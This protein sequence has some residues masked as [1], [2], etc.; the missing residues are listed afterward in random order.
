MVAYPAAVTDE[1]LP[2]SDLFTKNNILYI[3]LPFCT[4]KCHYCSYVTKTVDSNSEEIDSY[5][6][7]L[8]KE[9]SLL[10]KKVKISSIYIGGGTPSMLNLLQL[11]KLYDIIDTYFD[12]SALEEYTLEGCPET[13]SS[14]KALHAKQRGITR[15]SIGVESFNDDILNHMNRRHTSS[16]S[17]YA[18]E[19]I[20]S[21]GLDL[22]ID[23]ITC[24][25]GYNQDKIDYDLKC[26]RNSNPTSVSTY[27]YTVKP[28][29]VDFKHHAPLL[30]RDEV[31]NQTRYWYTGLKNLG[32][33]QRNVDWFFVDSEKR[34]LHQE[35]KL[36]CSANHIVLGV[37]GYGIIGD[38]QYYNTKSVR[39]YKQLLEKNVLPVSTMQKLTPLELEKRK[40]MFGVR[41]YLDLSIEYPEKEKIDWLLDKQLLEKSKRGLILTDIGQLFVN[42]IQ[43]YLVRT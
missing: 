32:Y 17:L 9:A 33:F 39:E 14:E 31:L 34:F 6:S 8:E 12:L 5:L 35:Y 27:K 18:I 10:P 16:D 11:D 24:Y 23:L 43:E 41:G 22:D 25:P 13:F 2:L 30:T 15:A 20:M 19:S 37:S 7:L 28:S 40:A 29:S 26:I 3:H 4:G 21:E 42:E 1:P 38:T 36:A